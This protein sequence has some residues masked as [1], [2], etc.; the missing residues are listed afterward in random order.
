MILNNYNNNNI[1]CIIITKINTNQ[2]NL[3]NN[4]INKVF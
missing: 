3:V 2:V 1:L 4:L